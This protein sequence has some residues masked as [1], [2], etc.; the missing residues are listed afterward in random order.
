MVR[1]SYSLFLP[2]GEPISAI[3]H[4]SIARLVSQASIQFRLVRLLPSSPLPLSHRQ[5]SS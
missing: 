4:L 5:S 1:D 2:S 3:L